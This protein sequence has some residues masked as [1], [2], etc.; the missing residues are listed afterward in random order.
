MVDEEAL[1]LFKIIRVISVSNLA[2]RLKVD[3]DLVLSRLPA[4]ESSGLVRVVKGSGCGSCAGCASD[5][6]GPSDEKMLISQVKQF[7][8]T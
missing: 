2:K 8:K 1:I 6:S 3:R 7:S 5:G 4:W